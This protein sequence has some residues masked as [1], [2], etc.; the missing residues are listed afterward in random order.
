[1]RITDDIPGLFEAPSPE[2]MTIKIDGKAIDDDQFKAEISEGI[3][4]EKEHRSPDGQGH[5][6]MLT[7]GQAP[8]AEAR[9]EDW[10]SYPLT[11]PTL[12][13]ATSALMPLP[14]LNS[15]LSALAPFAPG[16][17]PKRRASRLF[18]TAATSAPVSRPSRW[19]ERAATK[20]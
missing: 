6:M 14:V 15:V 1:M 2:Q 19:A 11:A 20:C 12:R 18:T 10:I 8:L 4:I 7:V 5:T 3:T 13:Q 16:N 9:Q 17:R